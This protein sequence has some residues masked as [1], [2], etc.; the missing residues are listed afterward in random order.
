GTDFNSR[1]DLGTGYVV[2]PSVDINYTTYC[3]IQHTFSLYNNAGA[4]PFSAFHDQFAIP[5]INMPA[6]PVTNWAATCV[7]AQ[8][9]SS[10]APKPGTYVVSGGTDISLLLLGS[11]T[12]NFCGTGL[13]LA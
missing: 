12:Y 7:G 9:L 13:T 3:K 4:S 8:L 1:I 5:D 6:L 11:G 10:A 2:A